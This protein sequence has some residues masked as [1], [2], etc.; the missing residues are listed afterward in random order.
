MHAYTSTQFRNSLSYK[1]SI[2]STRSNSHSPPDVPIAS[3]LSKGASAPF[4]VSSVPLLIW[5]MAMAAPIGL[6]AQ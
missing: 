5:P 2:P 4:F 3:S 1:S 6:N